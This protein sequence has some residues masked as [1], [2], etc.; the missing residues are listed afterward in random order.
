LEPENKQA[1]DLQ[2]QIKEE[3]KILEKNRILSSKNKLKN[4]KYLKSE[5]EILKHFTENTE[6][7]KDPIFEIITKRK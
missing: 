5:K 1:L 6:N 4:Y 2:Q 3:V 7:K